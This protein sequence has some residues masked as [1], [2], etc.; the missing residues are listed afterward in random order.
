MVFTWM[1]TIRAQNTVGWGNF[2]WL[3][4]SGLN[5]LCKNY[6][7]LEIFKIYSY[8][9]DINVYIKQDGTVKK[10]SHKSYMNWVGS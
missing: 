4:K 6:E 1:L 10:S 2:D 5:P 7:R 3:V 8:A 9:F